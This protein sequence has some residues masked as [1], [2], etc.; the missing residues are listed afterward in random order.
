MGP[1]PQS[2][3][4]YPCSRSGL[5][6]HDRARRFLLRVVPLTNCVDVA[7]ACHLTFRNGD[8]PAISTAELVL[9]GK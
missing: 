3:P 2:K 1:F 5:V 8:R 6:I 4:S 9:T 7:P